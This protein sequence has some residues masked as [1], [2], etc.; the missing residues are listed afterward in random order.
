MI[1]QVWG[2]LFCLVSVFFGTVSSI[3]THRSSKSIRCIKKENL[4]FSDR[5]RGATLCH[6]VLSN[7]GPT[8]QYAHIWAKMTDFQFIILGSPHTFLKSQPAAQPIFDSRKLALKIER[9]NSFLA[10]N[11]VNS[12]NNT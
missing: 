2:R 9:K 1:L 7:E 6:S 10:L 3:D 11:I 12:L 5:L 8:V 4:V